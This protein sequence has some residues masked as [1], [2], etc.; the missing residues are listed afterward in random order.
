MKRTLPKSVYTALAALILVTAAP[1]AQADEAAPPKVDATSFQNQLSLLTN[2][3]GHYIAIVTFEHSKAG[4]NIGEHFFYGDGE[5][6]YEQLSRGRGSSTT[7]KTF[8]VSFWAPRAHKSRDGEIRLK[9]G[10]YTVKCGDRSTTFKPVT[11]ATREARLAKAEFFKRKWQRRAYLL[12]RDDE[13]NYYYVDRARTPHDSFDFHL[14]TGHRGNMKPLPLVNIVSDTEGDI[15]ASKRGRLRLIYTAARNQR[16]KS[17]EWI[18]GRARKSLTN[19][20]VALNA[21]LIY[22]DLGVYDGKRLGTPCDDL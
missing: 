20:P 16:Q 10:Q 9:D 21:Q 17:L 3:E 19:V 2:D 13:G 22:R 7:S 4:D 6:F 1:S 5:R 11:E 15:F 18:K 12:A 14:Y 8:S